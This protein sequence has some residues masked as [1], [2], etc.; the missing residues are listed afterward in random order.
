MKESLTPRE[1]SSERG[2]EKSR[3]NPEIGCSLISRENI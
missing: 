1:L 2:C 3:V